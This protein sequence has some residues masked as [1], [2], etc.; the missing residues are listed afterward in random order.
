MDPLTF[1]LELSRAWAV[2]VTFMVC[3]GLLRKPLSELLPT[4][5]S[6]KYKDQQR[7]L[8]AEFDKG[9][10][11]AEVLA[12]R[13]QLPSAEPRPALPAAQITAGPVSAVAGQLAETSPEAAVLF[14]WRQLEAVAR[15]A[16][17]QSGDS[18]PD[19]GRLD[20]KLAQ[21]GLLPI[22][23]IHLLDELSIL[24]NQLAHSNGVEVS[25]LHAL[26]FARLVDRLIIALQLPDDAIALGAISH[27]TG[28][29]RALNPVPPTS[30]LM[31]LYAAEEQRQKEIRDADSPNE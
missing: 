20:I 30:P 19:H 21:R 3:I 10:A 23:A 31:P 13:A 17:R 22:D 24:R 14:A 6:V 7:E 9:L 1:V 25:R 15:D 27:R 11:S 29:P 28:G 5:A 4:L 16:L 2:P 26:E 18:E 8:H 12:D